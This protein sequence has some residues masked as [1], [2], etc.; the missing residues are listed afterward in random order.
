MYLSFH[1]T[2]TDALARTHRH[3]GTGQWQAAKLHYSDLLFHPTAAAK[4]EAI[5]LSV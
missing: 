2:Q 4:F 1:K 5:F 3:T